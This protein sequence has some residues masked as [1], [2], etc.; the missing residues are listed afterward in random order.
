[1]EKSN[2]AGRAFYESIGFKEVAD[3]PDLYPHDDATIWTIHL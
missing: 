1:M 2:E 3:V